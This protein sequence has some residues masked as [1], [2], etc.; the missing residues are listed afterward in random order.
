MK[1]ASEIVDAIIEDLSDRRGLGQEWEQ[2]D[3]EIK[4]E[5]KDTWA[6]IIEEMTR[7]NP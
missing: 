4:K 6:A 1:V 2:V 7:E 5:I 3:D